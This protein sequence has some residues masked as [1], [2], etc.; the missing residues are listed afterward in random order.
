M[1][2]SR[3]PDKTFSEIVWQLLKFE[4]HTISIEPIFR[5]DLLHR[6][7][8]RVDNFREKYQYPD[9]PS[10]SQIEIVFHG[11]SPK[12]IPGI[13][14]QGFL[15][16][17]PLDAEVEGQHCSEHGQKWGPGIYFTKSHGLAAAYGDHEVIIMCAVVMGRQFRFGH[18]YRGRRGVPGLR[19]GF[20]SHISAD[21]LE[22][23]VFREDQILPLCVL[24][25][26]EAE[27]FEWWETEEYERVEGEEIDEMM[28]EELYKYQQYRGAL[29]SI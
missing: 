11:T 1:K 2:A 16:P 23:A 17:L 19:R 10:Y 22:G 6:F 25:L 26:S 21:R 8:T 27:E 28:K 29:C 3:S 18:S 12:N 9:Y 20:D 13:I 24:T 7:L 15:L 14:Q 4:Y 5:P